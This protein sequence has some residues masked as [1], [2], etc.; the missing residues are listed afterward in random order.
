VYKRQVIN[1]NFTAMGSRA[2]ITGEGLKL[3]E[4]NRKKGIFQLYDLTTDNEERT[5]LA[6][7]YP[8]KVAELKQILMLEIDSPRPDLQ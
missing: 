8:E 6:S 2:L 7:G 1:N 4:A 5:N 3:V